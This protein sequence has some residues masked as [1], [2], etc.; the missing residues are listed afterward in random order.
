MGLI[1]LLRLAAVA[2]GGPGTAGI[3]ECVC[4]DD[5][6]D[7]DD[8]GGVLDDEQPGPVVTKVVTDTPCAATAFS[9]SPSSA[10]SCGPQAPLQNIMLQHGCCA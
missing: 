6:D 5:D 7:D 4:D 1:Q 3:K 2:G 8:G 9:R 10:C